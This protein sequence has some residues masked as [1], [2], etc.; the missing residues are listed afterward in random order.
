MKI[1]KLITRH[2]FN[3][4]VETTASHHLKGMQFYE[5]SM[6]SFSDVDLFT[7]ISLLVSSYAYFSPKNPM[8]LVLLAK[9]GIDTAKNIRIFNKLHSFLGKYGQES[10]LLLFAHPPKNLNLMLLPKLEQ[11]FLKQGFISPKVGL[12]KTGMRHIMHQ[13]PRSEIIRRLQKTKN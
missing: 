2:K 5:K 3:R 9:I 6:I 13:I 1:N 8:P 7:N 4:F 12:T 10:L 11:Q